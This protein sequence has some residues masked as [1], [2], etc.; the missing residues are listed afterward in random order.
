V[1]LT[2]GDVQ[3]FDSTAVLETVQTGKL[4]EN[5]QASYEGPS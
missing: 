1:Q 2:P 3:L 4:Q 5:V